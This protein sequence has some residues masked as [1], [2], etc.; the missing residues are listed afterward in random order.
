MYSLLHKPLLKA[1]ANKAFLFIEKKEL[2]GKERE[3]KYKKTPLLRVHII[4]LQ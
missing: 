2:K 3:R 4:T 1:W